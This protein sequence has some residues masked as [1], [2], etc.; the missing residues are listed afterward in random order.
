M[1]S[2]D[3]SNGK[4]KPQTYLDRLRKFANSKYKTS[5][6]KQSHPTV[7]LSLN[8]IN[9]ELVPAV[10]EYG[11]QIPSPSSSY[12]DWIPTDPNGTN[13]SLQDKNKNNNYFIKPLV[14][15]VKYWNA[16]NGYPYASFELEQ[17]VVQQYYYPTTA[18]KDLFYQFWSGIGYSYSTAQWVKDRVDLAKK[19]T[20]N[21]QAYETN[22][23]PGSAEIEIK[24]VIPVL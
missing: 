7:V 18:L 21:A 9:F 23:Q 11:Y 24:K 6:I 22:N 20:A 1:V 3:I 4:N 8:H 10:F 12:L 17:Y 2:F 13:Q 16:K 15:L 5:E 14:R 19:R